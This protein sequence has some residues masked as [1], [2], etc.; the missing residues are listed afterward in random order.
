MGWLRSRSCRTPRKQEGKPMEAKKERQKL[1]Q[2]KSAL[3]N[4]DCLS[5]DPKSTR[6]WRDV[7]PAS[8]AGSRRLAVFRFEIFRGNISV[9]LSLLFGKIY[10]IMN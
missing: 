8:P 9:A 6:I 3:T 2:A 1:L 5:E 10:L 7:D 4:L